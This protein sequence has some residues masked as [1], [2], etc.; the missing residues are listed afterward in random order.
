MAIV[1]IQLPPVNL[2]TAARPK[3]CPRCGCEILQRW[4]RVDKPLRDIEVEQVQVY[5]FRC[6]NAGCK[7]TFRHYPDGVDA[8]DMSLR[9]RLLAALAWSMGLSLRGVGTIFSAF[10][11][12]L[13][14]SRMSVWRAVQSLAEKM[15][16]HL[17]TSQT[18]HKVRVLGVDGAWV[19]LRGKTT[20]VMV[21]VDMGNGQMVQMEVLNERDPEA[22]CQWLR[23]L[24][25]E[26]GVEVM[27]TDDLN[28]Y[29]G[30]SEQLG[31]ERQVCQFH[32]LRWVGKALRELE[33]QIE[34]EWPDFNWMLDQVRVL[35]NDLPQRGDEQLLLMWEAIQ[36]ECGSRP[37]KE[38]ANAL[39]R[40]AGLLIRLCEH[41]KR[42][43][44][45]LTDRGRELGV[46]STNNLT[47][48]MIG[49]GKVRSRTVRGYKSKGGVLA[50][51]MVCALRLV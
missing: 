51:F 15:R 10:G 8:A 21:A 46:P 29:D 34:E 42:Y 19:R 36:K 40:L 31:V 7:A 49:N 23:P 35:V 2:T 9:L 32:M 39:H 28:I 24:V 1:R 18:K 25:E 37:Q 11:A 4:G 44:L 26:L 30:V 27:V 5:R 43:R 17:G 48:Q 41:W 16:R 47:E 33:V 3:Q 20:G 12:E 22:V 45:F 6:T 38:E 14:V 50:A 13:G